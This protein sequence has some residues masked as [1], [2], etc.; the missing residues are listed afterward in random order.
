[1]NEPAL[2]EQLKKIITDRVAAVSSEEET[3]KTEADINKIIEFW[4]SRAEKGELFY[5]KYNDDNKSLLTGATG[6]FSETSFPT[7]NSLRDVDKESNLHVVEEISNKI[8]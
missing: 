2:L 1:M 7:L 3:E 4:K 6:V 8:V 5:S